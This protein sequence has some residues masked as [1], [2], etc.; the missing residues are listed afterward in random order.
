MENL[1]K[2]FKDTKIVAKS[3][4]Q[5][6]RRVYEVFFFDKQHFED[7][8]LFLLGFVLK[9]QIYIQSQL[10]RKIESLVIRHEVYHLNDKNTWL[11]RYGR[12]IR[13]NVHTLLIDPMGYFATVRYSLNSF[14]LKTYF[15]L[16]VWPRR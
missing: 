11:G 14:R 13:A 5:V 12:E 7:E 6:D 1:D 8:N 16:Y 10:P 9:E 3:K 2:I 4:R 15:R